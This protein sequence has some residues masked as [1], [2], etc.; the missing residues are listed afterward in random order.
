MRAEAPVPNAQA[1]AAAAWL[2]SSVSL[3]GRGERACG[4]LFEMLMLGCACGEQL[5][6]QV[7]Q[8][9]QQQQALQQFVLRYGAAAAASAAAAGLSPSSPAQGGGGASGVNATAAAAVAAAANLAVSQALSQAL[10]KSIMAA[11]Q[12]QQQQ[13][14]QKA[15]EQQQAGAGAAGGIDPRAALHTPAHA[16]ASCGEGQPDMEARAGIN[17]AFSLNLPA[18]CVRFTC[19]DPS[20]WWLAPGAPVCA[21]IEMC[22][23]GR[24]G[25]QRQR[26]RG[27]RMPWAGG[28]RG[29]DMHMPSSLRKDLSSGGGGED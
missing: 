18:R 25:G 15:L 16:A 26:E 23:W 29:E 20:P 4:H 1:E 11:Q 28:K 12:Q 3:A 2:C 14:K 22:G 8:Q 27:M 5:Q 19:Q 9:A 7:I 17:G 6:Q 10:A 21:Y 24:M 13:H